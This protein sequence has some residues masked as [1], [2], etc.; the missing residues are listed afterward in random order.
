MLMRLLERVRVVAR[1]WTAECE[2][3]EEERAIAAGDCD[4]NVVAEEVKRSML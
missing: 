1:W 2:D 3:V 4:S